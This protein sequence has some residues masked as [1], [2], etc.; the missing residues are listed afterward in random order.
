MHRG[1][2]QIKKRDHIEWLQLHQLEDSLYQQVHTRQQVALEQI[3]RDDIAALINKQTQAIRVWAQQTFNTTE[4]PFTLFDEDIMRTGPQ[5]RIRGLAEYKSISLERACLDPDIL[6]VTVRQLEAELTK[7]EEH[8]KLEIISEQP[9]D[10][11]WDELLELQNV[12]GNMREQ[13]DPHV[14]GEIFM[15][16]KE[17]IQRASRADAR[18]YARKLAVIAATQPLRLH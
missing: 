12:L 9:S 1:L 8:R 4:L 5:P 7:R 6:P 10:E 11:L 16:Q 14:Q 2:R 18:Q 15:I 3:I 13:F 17:L